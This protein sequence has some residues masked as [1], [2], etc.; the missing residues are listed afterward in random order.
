MGLFTRDIQTF[1]DLYVHQ[2]QDIYYAEH[3]ITKALPKM[4]EKATAPELKNAFESHLRETEGQIERL[5]RVFGQLG[6]E[7]K[8]TTC[9]AIEG[10]I[11]EANEVAGEIADKEVLD[12]ALVAAGQSVEHYEIARYGTLI[13]WSRLLGRDDVAQILDETLAEEKGADEKLNALSID[14]INRRAAAVQTA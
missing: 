5:E 12:A 7:I 10:I 9:P 8:G 1:D 11:K 13:A 4:I 6:L 3:Q 14:R 2:L